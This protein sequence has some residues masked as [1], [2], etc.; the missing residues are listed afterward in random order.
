[1][2]LL[3]HNSW[4]KYLEY[5]KV[6]QVYVGNVENMKSHFIMPSVLAKMSENTSILK[7]NTE[8]KP[9]LCFL[10]ELMDRQLAMK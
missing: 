5:I 6:V 10:L 8:L 7:I 9:K 2:H 4:K 1:M 3:I